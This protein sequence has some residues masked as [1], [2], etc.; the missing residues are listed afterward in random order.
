MVTVLGVND[1]GVSP[2]LRRVG[3]LR[4]GWRCHGVVATLSVW[5]CCGGLWFGASGVVGGGSGAD[6]GGVGGGVFDPGDRGADRAVPLSGV[7]GDRPEPRPGRVC[8]PGGGGDRAAASTTP[9]DAS[10][11][12]RTA[13]AG[14]CPGGSAGSP[15]RRGRSPAG[16]EGVRWSV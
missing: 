12:R 9:E 1:G 13:V 8:G 7:T 11:G 2:V 6:R 5:G 15:A 10:L 16:C 3:Y 14:P 4:F